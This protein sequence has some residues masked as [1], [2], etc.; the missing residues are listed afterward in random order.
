MGLRKAA[1]AK[2]KECI[3]SPGDPGTWRQQVEACTSQKCPLYEVRPRP[4]P[5]PRVDTSEG[6][7]SILARG[8]TEN[9]V[10]TDL[11]RGDL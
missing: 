5:T 2:C 6:R 3:Y 4:Y 9:E 1:D 11:V 8:I 7:K 10:K